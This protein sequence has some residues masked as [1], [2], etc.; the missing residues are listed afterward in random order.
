MPAPLRCVALLVLAACAA[1]G[2]PGWSR[3]LDAAHGT[4]RNQARDLVV[5]VGLPGRAASDRMRDEALPDPRV[6]TALRAGGFAAVAVDAPT[7]VDVAAEG[8]GAGATMGILVLDPSGVPCAARPGPQD[9]PEL[10]AFLA[11]AAARRGVLAALRAR[12]AAERSP[13]SGLRLGALLVESGC[14]HEAEPLLR[15]AA[16]AGHDE[17]CGLL[18]LLC[19]R[20]GR[21]VEAREWL[22]RARPGPGT[23]VLDGYLA[24]KERRHVEAVHSLQAAVQGPLDTESA[25]MARLYLGKALHECR[26]DAEARAVLAA[27]AA[28]GLGSVHEGAALH[29][30]R[31]LD[32]PDHGHDH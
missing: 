1:Q 15:A 22:A 28:E 10:A 4:A 13:E 14:R 12:H 25:Q 27:L 32:A 2:G 29:A 20:Q 8:I 17:A 30:L 31:H 26:R 23:A 11:A 21:L 7:R 6:A 19:G 24:F 5:F 3:D 9:A 16:A 18:A